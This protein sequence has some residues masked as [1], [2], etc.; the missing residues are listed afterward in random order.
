MGDVDVG[1]PDPPAA[2]DQRRR[3]RQ[4]REGD[5]AE[6]VDGQPGKLVA[7]FGLLLLQGVAQQAAENA[8]ADGL[9][10][11]YAAG[12]AS[13]L[14]KAVIE[15][16]E[17][18]PGRPVVTAIGVGLTDV[19]NV[20]NLGDVINVINAIDVINVIDVIDVIAGD[21]VRRWFAAGQGRTARDRLGRRPSPRLDQYF[22]GHACFL[23]G[24][25]ANVGAE[26]ER[27]SV[28]HGG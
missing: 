3:H 15:A 12:E 22:V 9:G 18:G 5:R 17:V 8:P 1:D 2:A 21:A 10:S 20:I 23:R 27:C 16:T 28:V 4:R 6:H 19:S 14:V 7:G 11:P 25:E 13:R 24:V 26:E